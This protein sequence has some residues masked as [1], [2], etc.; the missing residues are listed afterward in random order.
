M[1]MQKLSVLAG[2]TARQSY[3]ARCAEAKRLCRRIVRAVEKDA[4]KAHAAPDDWG[5]AGHMGS[6]CHS[7]N[8]A[9]N[10][11]EGKE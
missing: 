6:V 9:L 2:Q 3:A 10:T 5:W 1:S 8:L 7:L 11:L 4:I